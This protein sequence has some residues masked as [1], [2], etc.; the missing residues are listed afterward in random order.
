[1]EVADHSGAAEAGA[2]D[3]TD[4]DSAGAAS[5]NAMRF[6]SLTSGEATYT[7]SDLHDT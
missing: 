1:V 3:V 6:Y 7:V 5:T 4:G 2:M